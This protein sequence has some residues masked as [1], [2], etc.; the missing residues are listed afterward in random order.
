MLTG[1]KVPQQLHTAV[2]SALR[3]SGVDFDYSPLKFKAHCFSYDQAGGNGH[4]PVYF[5]VRVFAMPASG[6]GE[7]DN[8]GPG[9]TVEF[10]RQWGDPLALLQAYDACE[11][12]IALS[13]VGSKVS[14]K[15]GGDA[16]GPGG[17]FK[18]ISFQSMLIAED[19]AA[20]ALEKAAGSEKQGA[21]V[22][23][24][25]A[26]ATPL[27]PGARM[28]QLLSL[29]G[30]PDTVAPYTAMATDPTIAE[31][32]LSEG[33]WT[34]VSMCRSDRF[35]EN[36]GKAVQSPPLHPPSAASASTATQ[37]LLQ[38]LLGRACAPLYPGYSPSATI[39]SRS[40]AVSALCGLL[41]CASTAAWLG[42]RA[43]GQPVA[44]NVTLV[45]HLLAVA[46][47][48][49]VQADC[50]YARREL[51]HAVSLLASA[52]PELRS[53]LVGPPAAGGPSGLPH[54]AQATAD[55]RARLQRLRAVAT[56]AGDKKM[57]EILASLS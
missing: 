2:C 28:K 31:E 46:E 38:A 54:Q 13:S 45:T 21:E 4:G 52:V 33:L 12:S 49:P 56:T 55:C 39:G 7:G 40:A 23:A 27:T 42:G 37:A 34:L 22:A 30:I 16:G 20:Y 3:S 29:Q 14:R 44:P 50:M 9:F 47:T 26:S 57:L 1:V 24:A 48:L 19:N 10:Q 5:I 15:D 35:V 32:R 17:P 6:G 8:S 25:E 53:M 18:D 41:R 36:V 11:K 43:Q 51:A